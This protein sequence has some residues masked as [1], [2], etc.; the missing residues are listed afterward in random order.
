MGD[1]EFSGLRAENHLDRQSVVDFPQR[2]HIEPGWACIPCF[3]L[4]FGDSQKCQFLGLGAENHLDRQSVVGFFP[5]G[6]Y[7]AP[8]ASKPMYYSVSDWPWKP[9]RLMTRESITPRMKTP[10][11]L[12]RHRGGTVVALWEWFRFVGEGPF[13][14]ILNPPAGTPRTTSRSTPGAHPRAHPERPSTPAGTSRARPGAP[15]VYQLLQN[16]S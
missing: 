12:W 7:S 15:K 13:R 10:L 1:H 3:R 6:S 2:A 5:W 4:Y 8:F 11:A 9:S 14:I 16:V